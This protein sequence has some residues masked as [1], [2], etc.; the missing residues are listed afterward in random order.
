MEKRVFLKVNF[1]MS[2]AVYQSEYCDE[3]EIGMFKR[4]QSTI[5]Y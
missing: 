1:S 3:R 5:S 2:V 4:D